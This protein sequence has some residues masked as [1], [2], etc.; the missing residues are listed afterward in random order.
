[1]TKVFV[2]QPLALLGSANE[3]YVMSILY[4]LENRA[5]HPLSQADIWLLP[6]AV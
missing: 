2:E 6:D 1:M 5:D 4:V 3:A